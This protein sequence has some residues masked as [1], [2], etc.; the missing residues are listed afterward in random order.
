V[1][2]NQTSSFD[3]ASGKHVLQIRVV[4]PAST[5]DQIESLDAD[6]PPGS[7]H[8]LQVNCDKRKMQVTLQ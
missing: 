4:S 6:L 3:L 2:M 8:V 5:Y 7:E 1:E